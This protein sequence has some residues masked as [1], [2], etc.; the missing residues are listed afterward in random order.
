MSQGGQVTQAIKLRSAL[1]VSVVLVLSLALAGIAGAKASKANFDIVGG[2]SVLSP[3]VDTFEALSDY[4][5][6]VT[7]VEG[8]KENNKGVVF[9]IEGGEVSSNVTGTIEHSGGLQFTNASGA[10]LVVDDF[11][12][13]LGKS[14]GKLFVTS[15]TDA[16][17][18]LNL[19]ISESRIS[20]EQGGALN[21]KNIEALLAKP[22]AKALTT[23][24][25]TPIDKGTPIG[26]LKVKAQ[27]SSQ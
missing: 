15:G 5:V 8:A 12:V 2:K 19:D 17:R 6:T 20:G 21:I 14:K 1:V 9:P 25:G 4:G 13:K 24:V 22:A 26:E 23:F 11:L 3:D 16:F 7:P 10:T 18:F 27:T